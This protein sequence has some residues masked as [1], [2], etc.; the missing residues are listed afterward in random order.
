MTGIELAD[1]FRRVTGVKLRMNVPAGGLATFRIGGPLEYLI[2]PDSVEELIGTIG[3]L[4][5][6]GQS[7]RILGAGSNLLISSD[8]LTGWHIK[9][10][11]GFRHMESLGGT[12]VSVGAA[13]GLMTLSRE[14][15]AQGLAGLEFAGGIPG[16][17][18]GA[19]RM[20]AG[21]YGGQMADVLKSV[22]CVDADG[23]TV[24]FKSSDLQFAYRDCSLP[25]G[26]IVC[27]AELALRADCKDETE[28]RRTAYL[29][30]RRKKSPLQ[31]PSAGS[32]FRNPEPAR[33]AGYLIEQ[34]GL[35]GAVAGGAK[36][37]DLHANWI[38]NENRQATHSDVLALIGMCQEK[39]EEKFGVRLHTEIKVWV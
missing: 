36:I 26:M 29:E 6:H 37:S 20:N 17:I 13:Y 12:L 25:A 38:I 22:T 11:H 7:W 3:F 14:L 10:G 2:E 5:S 28:R 34:C 39:V 30:E 1:D 15:C 35:K 9:L 8:G 18:G 32:V 31:F 21:A 23:Q 33:S 19:I 4:R 24:V 27:S 16:S